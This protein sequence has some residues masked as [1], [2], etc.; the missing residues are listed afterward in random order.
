MRFINYYK[1]LN[2]SSSASQDEIK[3]AFRKLAL[4]Y[5][6]D[7]NNS[8]SSLENFKKI[9][10][11]YD[12]LKDLKK[13]QHYDSQFSK[14]LAQDNFELKIDPSKKTKKGANL[15]YYMKVNID[16]LK[17]GTTKKITYI[18][19]TNKGSEEQSLSVE[20]PPLSFSGQRL[21]IAMMGDESPDGGL[22]GDLVIVVEAQDTDFIQKDG[23]NVIATIPITFTEAILGTKII[24]PWQNDFI[25]IETPAPLP[26]SFIKTI[27][28]V[29]L[30]NPETKKTGHLILNVVVE[31]PPKASE[32]QIAILNEIIN[33]LPQSSLR[34]SFL[35]SKNKRTKKT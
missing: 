16:E 35:D 34:K 24:F 15:K 14:E 18:K 29:G 12:L 8:K 20:I 10:E 6:P 30:A 7:R 25:K 11:A 31:V 27:K 13:R 23:Y 33:R 4:Q 32:E 19:K 1:L 17:T 2:I 3:K 26:P 21:K 28:G 5:H 22:P 9:N